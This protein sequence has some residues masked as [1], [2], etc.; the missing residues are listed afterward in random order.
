[1]N[2][3][4]F[5]ESSEYYSRRYDNFSSLVIIPIFCLVVAMLIFSVIGRREI[6][7][8]S[9]GEIGPAKI[10]A[11]IQ[12][13]SGQSIIVNNLVENKAIH[14]GDLL[15]V[16]EN[17]HNSIQLDDLQHQLDITNQRYEI[18]QLLKSGIQNDSSPF[19]DPDEFGYSSQLEDYRAQVQ[20]LKTEDSQKHEFVEN[21]NQSVALTRL[22]IEGQIAY[23]K[24]LVEKYEELENAVNGESALSESNPFS[25]SYKAYQSQI[26]NDPAEKD[27][28]S[29]QLI[30]Q[31]DSAVQKLNGAIDSLQLQLVSSSFQPN[32][33]NTQSKLT[34]LKAEFL[35]NADKE[36]TNISATKLEI[37]TQIALAQITNA[38]A[39]VTAQAD[40]IIHLNEEVRGMSKIPEGTIIGQIYPNLNEKTRLNITLEIPVSDIVSVQLGQVVR[41]SNY[42]H[43][44]K[45]LILTG[46]I[47]SIAASPT[48]TKQGNY[49]KVIAATTL[50]QE[51]LK[52]VRYG[53]EGKT[54]IVTGNKSFFNYYKDLMLHED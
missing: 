49:Y 25:S 45:P 43:S 12:S 13:T 30:S 2:D 53:Y 19:L 54:V 50:K 41:L 21:Q 16:Y 38:K 46:E 34:Q 23:N 33:M 42:R 52:Q 22:A 27:V 4:E 39:S 40:G 18:L 3:K 48:R 51:Q 32:Q 7:V 10:T 35:L 5:L 26:T 37:Q 8:K 44:G 6:T 15:L 14:K 20:S 29:S 1:M 11:L 9:V 31:I 28:I 24:N 36:I 47:C 17:A